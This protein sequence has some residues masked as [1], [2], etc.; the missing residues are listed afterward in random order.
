MKVTWVCWSAHHVDANIQAPQLCRLQL[1]IGRLEIGA[2]QVHD[3]IDHLFGPAALMHGQWLID[4]QRV[5]GFWRGR[6]GQRRQAVGEII[7]P[8]IAA[9]I[10]QVLEAVIDQ[11]TEGLVAALVGTV[12]GRLADRPCWPCRRQSSAPASARLGRVG[13][14]LVCAWLEAETCP[15]CSMARRTAGSASSGSASGSKSASVA[16]GPQRRRDDRLRPCR[17]AAA[18]GAAAAPDRRRRPCTAIKAGS[19]AGSTA[20]AVGHGVSVGPALVTGGL[21]SA[22][23]GFIGRQGFAAIGNGR[24]RG[25]S[26]CHCP[27][28]S[29]RRC[30][31]PCHAPAWPV[32]SPADSVV[33]ACLA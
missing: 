13:A 18:T 33:R 21:S 25:G 1:D 22:C 6:L 30:P 29:C 14:A 7:D 5:G 12:F 9:G 15:L 31:Q 3:P 32:L 4:R 11:A 10:F 23:A 19:T 20:A 27:H 8:G 2:G 28:P 17:L 16:R 24:L 26:A